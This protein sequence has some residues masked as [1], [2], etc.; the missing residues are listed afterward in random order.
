MDPSLV[1]TSTQ[2]E[3]RFRKREKMKA[4]ACPDLIHTDESEQIEVGEDEASDI[5]RT[6]E[7]EPINDPTNDDFA[8]RNTDTD[9]PDVS[10]LGIDMF[11]H[12]HILDDRT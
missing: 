6:G 4:V 3:C 1:L 2:K 11:C 9:G 12:N 8:V 5:A 10:M 7:L